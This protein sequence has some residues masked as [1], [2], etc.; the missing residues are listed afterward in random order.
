MLGGDV[1]SKPKTAAHVGG[2]HAYLAGRHVQETG[3]QL[4][5]NSVGHL[6]AADQ[7]VDIVRAAP[8]TDGIARLQRV[9][10]DPRDAEVETA[11]VSGSLKSCIGRFSVASLEVEALVAFALL[12][13]NDRSVIAQRI[14]RV[15]DSRQLLIADLDEICGGLCDC[16]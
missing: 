1:P 2:D 13:P 8:C 9:G 16:Q 7:H 15:Y 4:L 12:R 6:D 14:F 5:T 3:C 11:D 10:R